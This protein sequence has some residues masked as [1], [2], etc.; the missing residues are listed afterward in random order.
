MWRFPL[1][2]QSRHLPESVTNVLV[3][4]MLIPDHEPLECQTRQI[5]AQN[6]IALFNEQFTFEIND[7][8][9]QKRL[10]F[11][12]YEQRKKSAS[13]CH[14]CFSFGI[15]NLMEKKRVRVTKKQMMS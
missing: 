2:F 1:V 5:I 6:G 10:C 12:L 14:G 9:R 11:A 15:R 8:D 4:I 7:E 3:K 13:I